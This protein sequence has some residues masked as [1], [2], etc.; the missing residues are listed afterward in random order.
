[1]AGGAQGPLLGVWLR[2]RSIDTGSNVGE[3][4]EPPGELHGLPAEL[5]P[6][7]IVKECMDAAPGAP[8]STATLDPTLPHPAPSPRALPLAVPPPTAAEGSR[9]HGAQ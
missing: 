2:G 6:L 7:A 1:M 3:G 4:L 5:A 8:N 9:S